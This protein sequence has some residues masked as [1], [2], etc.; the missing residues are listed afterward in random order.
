MKSITERLKSP[1]VWGAV[2][3]VVYSQAQMLMDSELSVKNVILSVIIVLCSAFS[4]INDPTNR[5]AL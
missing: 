5:D 2:L 3:T 1:V 4:A